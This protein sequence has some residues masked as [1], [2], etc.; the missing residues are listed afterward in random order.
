V[1]DVPFSFGLD[2]FHLRQQFGW[3][4]EQ[5]RCSETLCLAVVT[6]KKGEPYERSPNAVAYPFGI[7]GIIL[8]MLL[9]R[10]I[11]SIDVNAEVR[12]VE[13]SLKAGERTPDFIDLEVT[14]PN[15]DG[16][17]LRDLPFAAEAGLVFSR[18]LRDGRGSLSLKMTRKSSSATPFDWL[19][20]ERR[21]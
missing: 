19:V 20:R 1:R 4:I 9:V 18:L 21:F 13:L 12:N 2:K 10:R 5:S 15:V 17:A 7:I 11:F 14:N 3:Q 8:T 16:V 6:K